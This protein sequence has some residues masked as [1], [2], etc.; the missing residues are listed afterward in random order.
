MWSAALVLTLLAAPTPHGPA[1]LD[2]VELRLE[3]APDDPN[4]L[5]A[6][7][8]PGASPPTSAKPTSTGAAGLETSTMRRPSPR[9]ATRCWLRA[10]AAC[11]RWKSTAGG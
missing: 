11:T 4:L 5:V 2:E 9:S 7:I 1:D 6:G 10:F 3:R 8:D